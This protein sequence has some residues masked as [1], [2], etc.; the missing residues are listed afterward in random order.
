MRSVRRTA[1]LLVSVVLACVAAMSFVVPQVAAAPAHARVSV[2]RSAA[3]A[4]NERSLL[5]LINKAR[6]RR[7][8]A[9][10]RVQHDLV[11]AA[12]LHCRQML[13]HDF[14]SHFSPD[15]RSYGARIVRCGYGR[16]GYTVWRVGEVLAWGE[17]IYG[18]PQLV[19]RRWMGS[20][21]HRAV[22][23]GRSWREV[24]VGVAKGEFCGMSG[25]F[26]YTVDFGRRI[27]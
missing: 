24:G 1:V 4:K 27:G 3:L 16:S 20:P 8:L 5:S 14:F 15:G 23:L 2:R 9:T 10:L 6:A 7:G 11:K 26:L 22:I 17:G 25:V 12:R 13:V 18:V 19:L 21:V